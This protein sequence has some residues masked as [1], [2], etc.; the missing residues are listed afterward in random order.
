MKTEL[1][2]LGHVVTNEG[3]K[4]DPYK[5]QAIKEFPFPKNKTDV[6]SFLGLTGY[7]R[8]FI[9]QC[10]KIA[11]PLNDLQKK[12]QAWIE[13]FQQLKDALITEPVLQYPDLPSHL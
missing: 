1:N 2:Y 5:I 13:S 11:K 6:K 10:S 8:K 4:P 9:L 3:V 7:Y 12:D